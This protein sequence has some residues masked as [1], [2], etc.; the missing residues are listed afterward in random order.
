MLLK[1]IF[2]TFPQEEIAA[3]KQRHSTDGDE[4]AQNTSSPP[5]LA[6]Q[7]DNPFLSPLSRS[8]TPFTS[9]KLCID[10]SPGNLLTDRLLAQA[11][12][13]DEDST[14]P[15]SSLSRL[16]RKADTVTMDTEETTDADVLAPAPIADLSA[17]LWS[18]EDAE[19]ART[20][21]LD[22]ISERRIPKT[23]VGL[24]E[25]YEYVNFRLFS[26]TIVSTFKFC[27]SLQSFQQFHMTSKVYDLLERT[28]AYGESNSC[29][30]VGNRGTGKSMVSLS[31]L[32]LLKVNFASTCVE[33][34]ISNCDT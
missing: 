18:E 1:R 21:I 14:L 27:V 24:D 20:S 11:S 10:G 22:R 34:L 9:G 29:L 31:S 30:L 26:Y 33:R 32:S 7:E 6:A 3:K 19:E 25:Q 2:G 12:S 15:K 4:S 16:K 8:A 28:I 17:S 5:L 13:D 23:L